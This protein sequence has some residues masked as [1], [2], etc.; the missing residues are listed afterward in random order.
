MAVARIIS[1]ASGLALLS[2]LVVS[3]PLTAHADDAAAA[4]VAGGIVGLAVGAALSKKHHHHNDVYYPGHAPPYGPGGYNPAWAQ[5][6]MPSSMIVCYPLQRACYNVDG[7][8][9]VKW[10]SRVFGY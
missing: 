8:F 10:T 6:F 5:S 9:S 3:Q 2:V 4:A 7:G 1:L